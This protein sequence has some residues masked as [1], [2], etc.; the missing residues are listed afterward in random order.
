MTIPT[1][2]ARGL[3]TVYT[4]AGQLRLVWMLH[5]VV[6]S[7]PDAALQDNTPLS[8]LFV[9][10]PSLSHIHIPCRGSVIYQP[11]L[12][13]CILYLFSRIA[14]GAAIEEE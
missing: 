1:H 7:D 3:A 12:P 8:L 5:T 11:G 10:S 13:E 4:P 9:S 2:P 14:A 6:R